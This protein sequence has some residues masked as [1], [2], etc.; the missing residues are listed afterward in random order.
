MEDFEKF[1][2]MEVNMNDFENIYNSYAKKPLSF[3]GGTITVNKLINKYLD[4]KVKGGGNFFHDFAPQMSPTNINS[5]SDYSYNDLTF[6]TT[7]LNNRT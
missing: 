4:K 1:K 3:G 6:P 2:N 5:M 7:V